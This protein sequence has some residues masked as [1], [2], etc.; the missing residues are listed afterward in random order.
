MQSM[1]TFCLLFPLTGDAIKLTGKALTVSPNN[2]EEA[3]KQVCVKY[4]SEVGQ[5]SQ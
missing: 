5:S 1:I 3:L 2:N 4:K